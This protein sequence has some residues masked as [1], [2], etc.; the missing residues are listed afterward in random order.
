MSATLSLKDVQDLVKI[1]GRQTIDVIPLK[2]S[3]EFK[4]VM[5]DIKYYDVMTAPKP[6]ALKETCTGFNCV[7]WKDNLKGCVVYDTCIKC[8]KELKKCT[9]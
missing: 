6:S 2:F 5:E 7:C 1:L 8:Y 4:K 9:C 3:I